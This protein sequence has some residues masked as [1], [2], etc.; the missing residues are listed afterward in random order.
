MTVDGEVIEKTT[1]VVDLKLPNGHVIQAEVKGS[2]YENT[3]IDLFT[4]EPY[5]S[6]I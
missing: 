2:L 1:L 3:L 4:E 6:S 5:I